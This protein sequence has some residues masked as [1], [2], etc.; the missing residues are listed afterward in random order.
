MS[1]T[2]AT[3][4]GAGSGVK[5][6]A[7]IVFIVAMALV[8]LFVLRASPQTEPFD[9]KSGDPSGARA[10]VRVLER[11]GGSV[12]DTRTVPAPGDDRR[13]F[14]LDD[15]LDD[16]Q[17]RA[18]LEFVED[19]GVAVIADPDSTL[20]GGAGVDG[21]ALQV[22]SRLLGERRE[23]VERESNV[24]AGRCNIE[25]LQRLRGVWA[26]DGLVFPVGPDEPQCFTDLNR[27]NT[28]HSFV[29]VREV[30]DGL[31]V[32]LGSQR[33]F[34]NEFLRRS[35]NAGLAVALLVPERGAGVTF[36]RGSDANPTVDDVGS[37]ED[38]LRDL[39]PTWVWMALV[40][41]AVGF[42]VFAISRA[43]GV[44][45]ILSEPIATPLPGSELVSA[46]GN[47]MERAGHAN[48]AGALITGRLYRDLCRAHDVDIGTR[49]EDL[50]RVVAQ[51]SGTQLGEIA[52][53]LSRPA[54]TNAG[55][56]ALSNDVDRLRRHVLPATTSETSH[57]KVSSP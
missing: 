8:V 44:G 29:V 52:A 4:T 14:V 11:S 16:D 46:T 53:L 5:A 48:R 45:K 2:A 40:L 7:G 35:D 56:V 33:S 17:R 57:E 49:Y 54:G 39:I 50:D 55:L 28:M 22:T 37:G 26:E 41:S 21:G 42:V 24:F 6:V 13:I 23:S 34:T 27:T 51:Q 19:G 36:L 10:L 25:A 1:R 3:S 15:R 31:I 43:V 9:P 32:G 38:T 20:H 18:V 30:G 47:L 12:T